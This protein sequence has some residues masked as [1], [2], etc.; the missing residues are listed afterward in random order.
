[1]PG[2]AASILFS[3][4]WTNR[5][6]KHYCT[7]DIKLYSKSTKHS[8]TKTAQKPVMKAFIGTSGRANTRAERSI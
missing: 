8:T 3:S 5:G 1:M 6:Q 2:I 4:I 7:T